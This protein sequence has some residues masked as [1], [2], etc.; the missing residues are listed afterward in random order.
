MGRNDSMESVF[1]ESVNDWSKFKRPASLSR[2]SSQSPIYPSPDT[3]TSG[4]QRILWSFAQL[5]GTIEIDESLIKPHDFESLKRRL[6]YG[7]ISGATASTN[8]VPST[9]RTLGGGDLGHS[10]EPPP[11]PTGWSSYLRGPFGG[12]AQQ[13]RR[14][15]STMQDAQ[16]RTLQSRSVPT[17]SA[18]PSIVAVDLVLAPGESK[19]F[20]FKLRLPVDLPPTYQGKAIRLRYN[21]TL[22]TNRSD[23]NANSTRAQTSRLIQ[24][25]IRIYNHIGESGFR[26]FFDLMNPVILTKEDASVTLV[27]ED[28]R[29]AFGAERSRAKV[30]SRKGPSLRKQDLQEYT[31]QLLVSKA[32][33]E[34]SPVTSVPEFG[35][36][37]PAPAGAGTRSC[38]ATIEALARSSSKVSYDIAKD[39]K[40]AA[41]LTLVRS[42]YRLGE[43]ITG[44]ININN[45]HSLARIARMSATLE[46][47]EDVQPS[48]ATLP[49]GRLQRVTRIIHAEHHESVLD[50]GRASFSLCIPSGAS[51]E[52]VTS[53]VKLN[54]LVRLSFLTISAT[55]PV[56]AGD[57][58]KKLAKLRPP[59]HLL[60]TQSDG[61]SRYHVSVRAIDSLAG[62]A[63]G[64]GAESA[65]ALA[66]LGCAR[67]TKLETVE[68]AVPVS[69][70]PNSTSYKVGDAEFYA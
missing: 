33:S 27:S 3:A 54:W 17:F 39:G 32:I 6:A 42:R 21:L 5:G 63:T 37:A 56:G 24:V 69:I 1:R 28:E 55:K 16:E 45:A 59:P 10:S 9:P 11:S 29:P 15:G 62:S 2:K 46:T 61:F 48:I 20:Q 4:S 14:T 60:P 36:P 68:C 58:E 65:K 31:R 49:A 53:G 26:P 13:H 57:I 35:G 44:V 47:F 64:L 18:P 66:E 23:A 41:V 8:S 34:G 12:R 22:G 70:L 67:E 38:K 30:A 40:V 51:P 19:T 52:F 25:P 7:D 43:T 50:K